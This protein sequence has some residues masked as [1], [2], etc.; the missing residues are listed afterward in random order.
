MT[1]RFV[2]WSTVALGLAAGCGG[3]DAGAARTPPPPA[4]EPP[5]ALN[6]DVPIAYPPGLYDR[7]VDGEVLLRLFVDTT[8]KLVAESTRVAETSGYAAFDSAAVAGASQLRFAPA[9]RHG[10][11][12]ATAFVQP[13]EFRHPVADAAGPA[14]PGA[15]ATAPVPVKAEPRPAPPVRRARPPRPRPDTTAADSVR[16][17]STKRDSTKRDS[18]PRDTTPVKRDSNA[19][20]H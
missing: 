16:R 3:S 12:V 9:R 5:V 7:N 19:V 2:R 6:A 17:D 1:P 14:A 15:A 10:L 20:T 4:E 8:G 13:V 11:P 18:T